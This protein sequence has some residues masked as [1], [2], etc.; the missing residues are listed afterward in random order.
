MQI[1]GWILFLL[2]IIRLGIA[3]INWQ[4]NKNSRKISTGGYPSSLSVLIPARN[5]EQNIEGLLQDLTQL[6]DPTTEIIVYND[7][8][9]DRT[10]AIV[11][12]YPHIRLI[13]GNEPDKGWLGKNY[14]CHQ[15][16]L[17]AKGKH[18][19][20]LDA[21]VRINGPAIRHLLCYLEQEKLRLLSLFPRQILTDTG[22]RF[23]VPLMNWILLSILPLPLIPNTTIPSL[24]AANGQCM[25]FKAETYYQLLPHRKFRNNPVE[26]IAII[27]YYKSGHQKTATLT[28]EK[29]VS[30]RMYRN[31][32]EAIQG[33]AKNIF[34]FFGN[35]QVTAYLFAL[36]TTLAPP[37]SFFTVWEQEQESYIY[38]SYW[39]S[40]YSFHW[41]V[42][43]LSCKI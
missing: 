37:R 14:A 38:F 43:N 27:R 7:Q 31:W 5:E 19:L 25:L 20:F 11:K 35:S 16:A 24:A 13:E 18:L 28:G 41:Q 17:A 29:E 9:T 40:G 3:W 4:F 8:S 39:G 26:D 1:A 12:S 6:K 10:A 21:D 15:L 36:L 42:I 34:A 33:F 23:T 30:C 32:K 22:S 2:G